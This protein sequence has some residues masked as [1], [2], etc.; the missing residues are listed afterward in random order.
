MLLTLTKERFLFTQRMLWPLGHGSQRKSV[1]NDSTMSEG[2]TPVLLEETI[3]MLA[4]CRAG[5]PIRVLDCTFG[6]GGHSEAILKHFPNCNLTAIDTDPEAAPRAAKLASEYPC[7]VTF[8]DANFND[9]GELDLGGRFDAILFDLG[10]SSFHFD[11]P[12]R[13]FSFRYD[14]DLDMRLN[15]REGSSAARFL[16]TASH[17]ELVTAIRDY[18]EEPRWRGVVQA[19]EAA[20]GSGALARTTS[21]AALVSDAVGHRFGRIHPATQVFQGVRMAVNHETQALENALPA[22][23]AKLTEN[24]VLAVIT[25][26]SIE[27]RIVKRYFR[28]EAG[29][30]EDKNDNLPQQSRSKRAELLNHRPIQSTRNELEQNP[31]ARSAKLRALRKLPCNEARQQP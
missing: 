19:I 17:D 2:H 4:Q 24:G 14:A 12:G 7:R 3:A 21:F 5:A 18:A 6:G 1:R 31:R 22:A 16:E 30:P 26:H 25:F 29:L 15:P 23:F 27:D 8:V 13:G 10:V 28:R 11:T 9:L 20:R